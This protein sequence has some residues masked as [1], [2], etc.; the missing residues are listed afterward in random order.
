MRRGSFRL[1]LPRGRRSLK[2]SPVL[3]GLAV[4]LVILVP[5]LFYLFPHVPD[6]QLLDSNLQIKSGNSTEPVL[7]V[8][9]SDASLLATV[10]SSTTFSQVYLENAGTLKLHQVLVR[11]GE[12]ALG[13]LSEIV[14]G[15]K[16][17]LAVS[18]PTERI[19]VSAL[20]QSGQGIQGQ[21]HY[22]S[23]KANDAAPKDVMLSTKAVPDVSAAFSGSS[24]ATSPALAT[25]EPPAP[26]VPPTV[27]KSVAS[28]SSLSL[29]ISANR[30]EGQLGD[31]VGYKCKA[32]NIGPNELSDVRII[33]AGKMSAT[34]FLPPHEELDLDGVL[35]IENNAEL[36]AGVDGK[37]ANGTVYTNNTSIAIRM[38]SP[39]IKLEVTAPSQVHRGDKVNFQIRIENS[40]DGL[41]TNLS[42]SDSFGEV[43][44]IDAINPGAFQVLQKERVISQSLQDE[45]TVIAHDDSGKELYASRSLSLR[46]RNSSLEISGDPAEVRTYP[47]NPVEVTWIL[48]NTGEELLRNITLGG[49]GKRLMLAEIPA[50]QSVRMAAIY[51]KNATT[52]INVTARGVDENGFEANAT[53][54][55]HLMSIQPGINLKVIPLEIE[56]CPGDTAEISSLVTNS[57]DDRLSGVVITQN[58]STLATIGSLEPGEFKVVNS[59]TVISGNCTIQFA[60]RG[61]DSSGKIWSDEA[62][63]KARTVVTAL[64]VFASASPPAV[65]PGEISNLSC[66]VANT[67]SVPLYSIFVISKKL[68]PLGNID[69]L[70]PKHQM[71]IYAEKA[72]T[73]AGADTIT[74]EGFT[75]D[76]KLVLG[77]CSLNIDL[78]R[79][80]AQ[81]KGSD[82]GSLNSV[83]MA[84]ANISCGNLSLP[85]NLPDE[86][87]TTSSI[88][89]T[90]AR[91]LDQSATKSNNAVVDGISNLLRYVETLLGMAGKENENKNESE[92]HAAQEFAP[93][94]KDS[95]PSGKD[96]ELSIEGVKSSEHG[97]ISILDVNA[98]PSQPASEEPVKVTVHMQSQTPITS[99]S[100]K[101]GL[102][103]SPL[104]K[105]SMLGVSR[106]YN[107]VLSLE[108]GSA[109]D[110]YWSCTIPGKSGGTY[111]P[112]SVWMTDGSNTAE[113][114]P[115]LI[116]WSTVK[117]APQTTT[118]DVIEPISGNGKLFI[119]SSS[120]KGEGQVSIKDSFEGAAMNYNERMMGNGS[121]SLDTQR[122]LDRKSSVNNFVEKKDLVFTGGNLIGHQTVGSPTFDGGMGASVTERFNLTHVDRSETSSVSSSSYTNN[123][124]NFKTEQAFNGTWDIQTK[125]AR[126]FKKIKAD[127]QYTG[128]FQTQ[129]EIKFQDAGQN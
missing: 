71:V 50:G 112:L 42:V 7:R 4:F 36:L 93:Q 90:M 96:Y 41:L 59:R 74:V 29:N 67:G 80:T 111:M 24:E 62:S 32:V 40:G 128:S 26:I 73:K 43:G 105:R 121:I 38:I 102:S 10:N 35:V 48:S 72:V 92:S 84:P 64:K 94:A 78:L 101:Y 88:S 9:S 12:K 54:C 81:V 17:V 14:P 46:V 45:V 124:L 37:D 108:S 34:K 99:A 1:R 126:L 127:Q 58:G 116:H 19:T 8:A 129:K 47:G 15:E 76:K 27:K 95:L 104:T 69:Y 61:K 106:V 85:F 119:E 82:S 21:V 123:T 33:C 75:Q 57:G 97:A 68:G 113:G 52:W 115:Y 51:S 118:R 16:K 11:N 20:D 60:I 22:N 120:V 44:R 107:S 89:G 117:S 13:T 6:S 70:S 98:M 66:T 79:G 109:K 55:V 2:A 25:P 31:A 23:T 3:L 83:R 103:D 56:V 125:Y 30:S 49:D 77:S 65:M 18:G 39:L 100:V 28:L 86:K 110:G 114:G 5:T 122:S 91:D 53:A 87:D 63:A